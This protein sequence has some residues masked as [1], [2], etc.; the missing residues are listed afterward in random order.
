[1]KNKNNFTVNFFLCG[2]IH[3]P[4]LLEP[5]CLSL[6][7]SRTNRGLVFSDD[8]N[9][10]L[11]NRRQILKMNKTFCRKLILVILFFYSHLNYV[12]TKYFS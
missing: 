8:D 12:I 4:D 11:M 9:D 7:K 10:K 6:N 5:K 2:I 3:Y 1:M